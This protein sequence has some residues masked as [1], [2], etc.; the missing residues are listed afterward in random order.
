[1][2]DL[3]NPNSELI[4]LNGINNP[5]G[6][7]ADSVFIVTGKLFRSVRSR[8]DRQGSYD[9]GDRKQI[10]LRKGF[11]LLLGGALDKDTIF[12]H[13]SLVS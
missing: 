2:R 13:R 4:I 1:M 9:F 6:P 12:C 3:H 11:Q 5:K 7:L 8:L 10:T